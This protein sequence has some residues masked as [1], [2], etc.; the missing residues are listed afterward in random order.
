MV[1]FDVLPFGFGIPAVV[2]HDCVYVTARTE[3]SPRVC[4]H[5]A[6]F[7]IAVVMGHTNGVTTKKTHGETLDSQGSHGATLAS[8]AT[9][10]YHVFAFRRVL[11]H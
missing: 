6:L 10:Y 8:L 2:G 1:V 11:V 4:Y 3:R 9:A 7:C 5:R